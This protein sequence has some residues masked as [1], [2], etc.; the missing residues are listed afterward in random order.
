[1]PLETALHKMTGMA[2]AKFHLPDRGTIREGAI[3]DLVVFDP[4]TVIDNAT[5]EDSRRTPEGM[6]WVVV[7]GTVV[8]RDG[9]HTG[10]R[11]GRGVRRGQ[12]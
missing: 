11:P 7:N 4:A 10:A 8:V 2:A 5:Y 12:S 1:M 3:A 9:V 6:P